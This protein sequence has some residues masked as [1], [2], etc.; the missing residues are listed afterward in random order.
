MGSCFVAQ[1]GLTHVG[2]SP[3]SSWDYRQEVTYLAQK[4]SFYLSIK[5]VTILS[6]GGSLL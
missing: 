1:A 6:T 4:E 5:T 3:L 2:L